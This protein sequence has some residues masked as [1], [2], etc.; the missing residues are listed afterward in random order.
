MGFN[1]GFK[2]LMTAIH[3]AMEERGNLVCFPAEANIVSFP[4]HLDRL[5]PPAPG[6]A[7]PPYLS[8]SLFRITAAYARS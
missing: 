2:G 4:N 5:P 7:V 1:S 3:N 6:Q 8:L